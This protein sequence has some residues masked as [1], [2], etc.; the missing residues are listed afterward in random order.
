MKVYISKYRS[1]WISPYTMMDYVFFWTEWSKC[2]RWT[3]QQTLEN[4]KREKSA[5]VDHPEWVDRWADRLMPISTAIN[6]ILDWIHPRITYVK[7]DRWDTWSMDST[8]APIVLPMLKQLQATKHGSPNI[9]DEDVPEHLRST[10]A[11]PKANEWDIDS[12]HHARWDWVLDEM[13]FAFEMKVKNDWEADFHSGVSDLRWVP[14]DAEGNEVAK[15]EH[16]YYR[17]ERG[18][19]DTHVYD[20]EGAQ[21]I[22]N[23]ITNGFRLFGKY[24]EGL[25][26]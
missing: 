17:T 8:L 15:G 5:W 4:E 22:Q 10:A 2:S 14:V 20:A 18:P 7:I 13:I 6:R 24:Y 25:W 16:R 1:H 12:N 21:K 9:D 3:L 19:A 11:L 26:D 23:R